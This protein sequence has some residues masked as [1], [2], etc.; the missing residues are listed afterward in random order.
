LQPAVQPAIVLHPAVQAAVPAAQPQV[1]IPFAQATKNYDASARWVPCALLFGAL[2]TVAVRSAPRAASTGG[3]RKAALPRPAARHSAL[4]MSMTDAS[5]GLAREAVQ[6]RAS[7]P[8]TDPDSIGLDLSSTEEEAEMCILDDSEGRPGFFCFTETQITDAMQQLP[9]VWK[10]RE[11]GLWEDGATDEEKRERAIEMLGKA[12]AKEADKTTEARME[13]ARRARYGLP[14]LPTVVVSPMALAAAKAE[15]ASATATA[16]AAATATI[17]S[18]ATSE[19]AVAGVVKPAPKKATEEKRP[20]WQEGIFAPA[21][22]GAKA[23]MGEQELK[24]FRAGVIAKHSKVIG[25]FVDTSESKFGQLVLKRMFEY[26]DKDGNGTLDKEEIQAALLDLGFDFLDEKQVDK[27]MKNA[28][29]D[30][31]DVI[32]FE[33]FCTATPK[34]L[35]VN[36]VKLAKRNGHD[37]G[38]LI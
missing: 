8:G 12:R 33:E 27:L 22:L 32:D 1:I 9:K 37:L 2:F 25:N 34:A 16:E 15:A 6:L 11:D 13:N 7:E 35:R 38:F 5:W 29:K 24:E 31:N 19:S 3:P 18:S 17:A 26:A 4:R 23:I 10:K 14:P 30:K 21:V 20:L 28:D 36:L